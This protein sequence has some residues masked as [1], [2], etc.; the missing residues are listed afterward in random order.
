[1]RAPTCHACTLC[2][3]RR[4]RSPPGHAALADRRSRVCIS[5]AGDDYGPQ[6]FVGLL[7]LAALTASVSKRSV[8]GS[9]ACGPL[10]RTIELPRD[11][12]LFPRTCLKP[13][14]GFRTASHAQRGGPGEIHSHLGIVPGIHRVQTPRTPRPGWSD[15]DQA[16]VATGHK[17]TILELTSTAVLELTSTVCTRLSGGDDAWQLPPGSAMDTA[18]GA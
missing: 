2:R 12:S 3:H 7:L 14:Q 15:C 6:L 4:R 9:A 8:A 1:M 16:L 13:I 17:G 10:G 5:P 11:D 18:E